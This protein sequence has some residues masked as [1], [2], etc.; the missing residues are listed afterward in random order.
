MIFL[1]KVSDMY[2]ARVLVC[3]QFVYNKEYGKMR[4]SNT[5]FYPYLPLYL[6]VY[7]KNGQMT[8]R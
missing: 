5:I 2:P 1:I 6:H 3:M 4:H 7:I 8:V